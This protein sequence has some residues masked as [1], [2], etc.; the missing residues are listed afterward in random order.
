VGVRPLLVRMDLYGEV[1][2][3]IEELDEQGEA[4]L[5]IQRNGAHDV[6]LVGVQQFPQRCPGQRTLGRDAAWTV[7]GE[8]GQF[9]GFADRFLRRQVFPQRSEPTAAP[10]LGNEDWREEER[11]ID[12]GWSLRLTAENVG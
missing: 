1:V 4:A 8:I 9:P 6:G 11:S 10:D 7:A 2:A 3:G 12:H 5:R